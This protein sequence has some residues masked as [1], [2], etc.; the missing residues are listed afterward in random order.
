M[1][2]SRLKQIF[3]KYTLSKSHF[4]QF[5][6]E[7]QQHEHPPIMDDPPHVNVALC[8]ALM[9]ARVEGHIFGHH[10]SQMS[11]CGATDCV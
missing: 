4:M 5:Q 1:H 8:E 10:E 6:Q 9:V 2:R 11:R 7:G 3:L